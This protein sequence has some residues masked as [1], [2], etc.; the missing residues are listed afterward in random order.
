MK[1]PLGF[2]A[3]EGPSAID[4]APIVVVITGIKASSNRKTGSMVQSFILRQ[5]L[6]PVEAIRTGADQSICGDC[7][8]RPILARETGEPP[9]YVETGKAPAAVWRAYQ[10]GRYIKAAPHVIAR[11]IA[12]RVLRIGTY[13]DPAAAPLRVWKALVVYA[14]SWTGYTHQWQQLGREWQLL[15]MASADTPAERAR[16][17]LAGWR[18]FRVSIGL[19]RQAGEIS[20]PASKEAG[21]RVQCIDCRLC[22]GAQIAARDIVISDHALGHKRRVINLQAAA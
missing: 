11:F 6:H 13:G 4:G 14:A 20:C 1:S 19:D 8:H 12:G 3:Y 7:R 5:D 17:K 10:R 22:R 21:A 18:T 9:C 2:I 16:A 15:L